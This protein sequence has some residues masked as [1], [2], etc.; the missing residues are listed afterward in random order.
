MVREWMVEGGKE[1][2][3]RCMYVAGIPKS[4]SFLNTYLLA[5]TV[6]SF[7]PLSLRGKRKGSHKVEVV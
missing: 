5:N 6:H 7:F 2:G 4:I 3:R 1:R